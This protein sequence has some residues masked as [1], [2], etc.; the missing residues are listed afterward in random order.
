MSLSALIAT[1][2]IAATIDGIDEGGVFTTTISASAGGIPTS[3]PADQLS[4]TFDWTR[5]PAAGYIDFTLEGIG[6]LFLSSY[7]FFGANNSLSDVTGITLDLLNAPAGA[8]TSRLSNDTNFCAAAAGLVAG[9]CNLIGPTGSTYGV[10]FT[11][12]GEF[13]FENLSTGSYRLGFFDSSTPENALATFSLTDS[14]AVVPLPAGG[15]L[16]IGALGA[17]VVV[18]RRK[19][20]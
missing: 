6:N 2:A 3:G 1:G 8:A 12:P 4:L 13:A 9:D 16:F 10:S 5:T 15:L 17:L 7:A 11:Q 20:G 18:R 19:K 14:I